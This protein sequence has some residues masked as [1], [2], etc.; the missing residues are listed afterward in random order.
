MKKRIFNLIVIL[1]CIPLCAVWTTGYVKKKKNED[2]IHS[3]VDLGLT[4]GLF[5]GWE[6]YN[7]MAN[8]ED[9]RCMADSLVSFIFEYWCDVNLWGRQRAS[10]FENVGIKE[11]YFRAKEEQ[12][13]L[14]E[15]FHS[16]ISRLPSY[17]IHLW[18]EILREDYR[19]ESAEQY[20]YLRDSLIAFLEES[21]LKLTS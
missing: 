4:G 7:S 6:V 17:S 3:H 14:Y 12:G 11:L 20:E 16:P 2:Y 8:E 18:E 15:K 9:K 1:V 21:Y 19:I 10:C 5:W 13:I